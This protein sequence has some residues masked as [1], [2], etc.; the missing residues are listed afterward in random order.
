[1]TINSRTRGQ[2]ASKLKSMR[3]RLKLTQAGL[4]RLVNYSGAYINKVEAER[5]DLSLDFA[6]KIEDA[7]K[8]ENNELSSLVIKK[9][10]EE[11]TNKRMGLDT[12][13]A[14]ISEVPNL[15]EKVMQVDGAGGKE[16]RLTIRVDS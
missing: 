16:I 2:I 4:A 10:Y 12:S 11:A 8:I 9:T 6:F 1:M 14:L 5:Q 15:I 3:S 7:L 13:R